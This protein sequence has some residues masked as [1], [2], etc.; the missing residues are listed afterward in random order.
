MTYKYL[1]CNEN[2]L[3][4]IDEQLNKRFENTFKFSNSDINRFIGLLRKSV[5]PYKYM[6]EWK[7]FNETLPKTEDFYS[8]LN[9]E[10]IKDS[11][12]DHAK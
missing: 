7:K 4:K 10:G 12:Y 2:Y 11:D 9:M 6:D 3:N 1:S 5:Y 8:N